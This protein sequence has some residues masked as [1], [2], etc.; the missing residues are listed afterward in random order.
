MTIRLLQIF[1]L[2]RFM[3]TFLGDVQ[4]SGIPPVMRLGLSEPLQKNKSTCSRSELEI[5]TGE[6]VFLRKN[7]DNFTI[8]LLVE[9]GIFWAFRSEH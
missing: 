8:C 1:K 4:K 7:R 2:P 9:F 5:K 6:F 3:G